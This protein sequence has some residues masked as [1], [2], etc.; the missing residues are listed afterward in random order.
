MNV[1]RIG[2]ANWHWCVYDKRMKKCCHHEEELEHSVGAEPE[3]SK[4]P[5]HERPGEFESESNERLAAANEC[6][7]RAQADSTKAA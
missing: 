4:L 1:V 6:G 7:N 3:E 2:S 5:A